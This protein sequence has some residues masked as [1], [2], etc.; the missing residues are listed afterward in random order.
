MLFR[1]D[2]KNVKIINRKDFLNDREYYSA[3]INLRQK[4]IPHENITNPDKII[5]YIL[6]E[7]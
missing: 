6:Y 4:I 5:S 2:S 3:I 7:K 1:I